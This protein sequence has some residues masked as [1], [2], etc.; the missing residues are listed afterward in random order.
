VRN[1][2]ADYLRRTRAGLWSSR[3]ALDDLDLPS[4]ECV[5]D[6]GCGT[7]EL[8]RVLAEEAGENCT[9]VGA[10]ADPS[11]LRVAREETGL[12]VVA[13][14]ALRLPVRDGGVDLVTC[15]ALLVNLPDPVAALRE[16]RRVASDAVAAVEPDNGD[17]AVESTVERE[18]ALERRVRE[19]YLDGVGTDVAMGNRAVE[20]FEAAGL[21]DVRTRRHYHRKIIEPPYDEADLQA[22]ARKATGAGLADHETEL[23]RAVGD[24]YHDLRA[25]WREMGREVVAAMQD[26]TYRRAE[27]V[28]FDVTVGRVP[29]ERGFK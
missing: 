23:R 14:D 22:A 11:L 21:V 28:P 18:V 27:V 4:R 5:L 29:A 10:D 7:G 3:E 15:Q 12:P 25:A 1:F 26:E 2:S 6:V 24:E 8:T 17:V 19:A 9:V 13:G 16:F 20:A